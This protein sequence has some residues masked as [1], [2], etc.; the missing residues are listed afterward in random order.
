MNPI[1][2]FALVALPYKAEGA[3]VMNLHA[4]LDRMRFGEGIAPSE[5]DRQ[6][7][8]DTTAAAVKAF[9]QE[10]EI[11]AHAPGEIDPEAAVAMN[12]AALRREVFFVCVGAILQD[13]DEP[14]AD[15]ALELGDADNPGVCARVRSDAAG[16]YRAYFDP[17][18]YA[19]EGGDVRRRKDRPDLVLRA[20]APDGAERA[21]SE[22]APVAELETTIDLRLP[23]RAQPKP[24]ANE[25]FSV[26][27][28]VVDVD[29][30]PVSG[31][32]VRA[33]DR[34]VG[35]AR[36][37][38]G[39]REPPTVT[40]P[41]GAFAIAYGPSAFREG[42]GQGER[43]QR[44]DMLFTLAYEER[45]VE[46]FA[47][48]RLPVDGDPTIA[49]ALPAGV[50]E[51]TLG[52]VARPVERVRIVL[53]DVRAP[54]GPS[55]YER[56]AEA[57]APVTTR[58]T[59]ADFDEGAN[60]D[61]RFAARECGL[62]IEDVGDMAGAH[63]LARELNCAPEHAF[64][65]AR[66][67]GARDARAI[68][69]QA[70]AALAGALTRA[71][72][73]GLIPAPPEDGLD[74]AAAR[75]RDAAAR[76]AM[77]QP[78]AEGASFDASLREAIPDAQ[79]RAA[80]YARAAASGGL[81]DEAWASFAA[82]RPGVDVAR[83]R[84]AL[85]TAAL[86]G[87]TP[88]LA[89]RLRAA[90]PDAASLR[91]LALELGPDAIADAAAQA[92]PAPRDGEDAEAAA[93]RVASEI[94]GVLAATQTTAVVARDVAAVA[95][96]APGLVPQL[97]AD[98]LA[99]AVRATAFD[100]ARDRVS[101][102][103]AA[104]ADTLFAG[105]N[106]PAARAGATAGLHRVQRMFRVSPDPVTLKTALS[107]RAADGSSFRG[108][109]DIAR[110]SEDA[111]IAR[112]NATPEQA[113]GLRTLHRRAA[114]QAETVSTLLVGYHQEQNEA[115]LAL[116][117]V[118]QALGANAPDAAGDGP[119]AA[120]GPAAD[121]VASLRD[122]FGGA[123]TCDCEDC[124]SVMGPAAYLVDLFEFLDKRCADK[125]GVTLLDVLIGNPDKGVPGRR[126]DLARVKL[127]CENT[128]TTIPTID[129]INEILESL[130]AQGDPPSGLDSAG[131]PLESSFGVT[132]AE[133]SAAPENVQE[134]AYEA[135]AAAVF[136]LSL[137]FDRLVATARATMALANMERADLL[138]LFD[139]RLA[140]APGDA[141]GPAAARTA[142]QVERL[143]LFARDVEILTGM[144]IDGAPAAAPVETAAL[145]GLDGADWMTDLPK[146]RTALATLGVSFEQ[147]VALLRTR[148]VGGEVPDGDARDIRARV[149]LDVDELQI[150]RQPGYTGAP[151]AEIE[152]ALA[153][154]RI[155]R[156]DVLA[157]LDS[158]ARK[159]RLDRIW[160]LDPPIG[161]DLD[162][163]RLRTLDGGVLDGTDAARKP[164]NAADWRRL[165]GFVRLAKRMGVNFSDLDSAIEAVGPKA[166]EAFT[167]DHLRA[168]GAVAELRR[169]CDV[170]WPSA[171]ALV[172]GVGAHGDASLYAQL[173]LTSG[174]ARLHPAFRLDANGVP[175]SA[176]APLEDGV[177]GIA[178]ALRVS[179]TEIRELATTLNLATLS[180]DTVSALHRATAL[181]G[182]LGI[183]ARDVVALAGDLAGPSLG[184]PADAEALLAFVRRARLLLDGGLGATAAHAFVSDAPADWKPAAVT[185]AVAL[186]L[187]A[188][189]ED[190]S[191][192]QKD[193]AT[194]EAGAPDS[195]G[196]AADTLKARQEAR[197][198][199][200][201]FREE[202][203]LRR[204]RG[205]ALA[206]AAKAL[207]GSPVIVAKLLGA[208]DDPK[209]ALLR[210]G[211]RPALDVL[212]EGGDASAALL[213]AWR[214]IT[215]AGALG[216]DDAATARALGDAKLLTQARLT[217]APADRAE[218]LGEIA[219]AQ[220][221]NKD[222]NRPAAL[223]AAAALLIQAGGAVTGAV[224]AAVGRWLSTP[225]PAVA[226][227]AGSP[228][229]ALA[230][231]AAAI[232]PFA[233]LR[234]LKERVETLRKLGLTAAQAA[235]C[236]AEPLSAASLEALLRGV[237]SRFGASGWL[238]ASRRLFDPIREASRDALVPYLVR[239][240]GLSDADQL[241]GLYFI[242]VQTNSFVLTSR[243]RQAIF[244]VQIFVQRCLMGQEIKNGVDPGQVN[245]KEW[246]ITGRYPTWASLVQA[247]L[248]P[249]NLL[250]PGWRD[251]K[252]PAFVSFENA[253]RQS[254]ATPATAERAYS[255][256]L[257]SLCA[258]ASLEVCGTFMQTV[259][260]GDEAGVYTSVL[261]VV[262]RS[263]SGLPRKY[264]YRRLNRYD[265]H[266]EWTAWSPIGSEIQGIEKDRL[267]P[268]ASD[269]SNSALFDAGVHV[270]PM[271]HEGKLH[272]F[273][274]TLVRKVDQPE[275]PP[276][277]PQKKIN[278]SFS[279]P[280]W[281][282][283]LCWSKLEG[284]AWTPKQQSSALFESWWFDEP[285]KARGNS[286]GVTI[287]RPKPQFP[288]PADL[289]L[290][291]TG[292][293][294]D[295]AIV[296]G[297]RGTASGGSAPRAGAI[298]RFSLPVRSRE[299]VAS[300]LGGFVD[301]DH[302]GLSGS[303]KGSYMGFAASGAVKAT[304]PG[305]N[306]DGDRLFNA[307]AETRLVTL[308][309]GFGSPMQA[310]LFIG[311]LGRSYVATP[312]SGVTTIAVETP[313]GTKDH[314][315]WL[316][317]EA[318]TLDLTR[319]VTAPVAV[320][321]SHPWL[322]TATTEFRLSS[323]S[324][325]QSA[326]VPQEL[327]VAR[328]A[329]PVGQSF[330]ASRTAA[331][332]AAFLYGVGQVSRRNQD[333]EAVDLKVEPFWHAHAEDFAMTLRSGGL[334]ALLSP[335][336]QLQ[337]LG[338]A[339]S[340]MAVFGADP[341]R[342]TGPADEG[343]AFDASAPY[344][345]YNWEIF[346]HAPMLLT[347]RLWE[348]GRLDEALEWMH[349]VLNPL[350][351]GNDVAHAW[352][353][354]PLRQVDTTP[355]DQLLAALSRLDGDPQ[356]TAMLAQIEVLRLFPF[357][358]HRI[359]RLRPA[360]YRR[361]AAMQYILLRVAI[362]DRFFRQF[363]PED[364]NASIQHYVIA[365][366]CAGPR[367]E[368]T[369]SRTTLPAMS[370]AELRPRL[371]AFGNVAYEAETLLGPTAGATPAASTAAALGVV[372]RASIQYF[373]VPKNKKLLALWDLVED[374]LYK[375]RNG[376][377]I[378]GQQ[379]QLPLF[380]PPIDPALLAEAAA[381]G[382]DIADVA[383]ALSAPPPRRRFRAVHR[384]AA[385]LAEAVARLGAAL[386]ETRDRRDSEE[387]AY[388]RTENEK[389]L[390]DLILD[391]RREQAAEAA[392]AVES[393][394]AERQAPL[395]RW[396][397]YR[398]LLGANDLV[399]PT[400][401]PRPEDAGKDRYTMQR[402]LKLV[403]SSSVQVGTLSVL[404]LAP[405]LLGAAFGG[406]GGA[407][408]MGLTGAGGSSTV[409]GPGFIAGGTIL[410]EEAGE[411][412]ESFIAADMAAE[413][414]N[415]EIL[416]SVLQ[417]I[418]S[419]EA[420]VKPLGGG[421]AVHFGG[422][423]LA[424]VQAAFSRQKQALGAAHSFFAGLLSKQAGFVLREHEWATQL[425]QAAADIKRAEKAAAVARLRKSAADKEVL[426]Q[427]AAARHAEQV[428][429][430]LEQKFTRMELYDYRI[431]RQMELFRR[432]FDVA[433]E[434]ALM[435]Q[436]SYGYEREPRTFMRVSKPA[437]ARGELMAGHELL[438]CLADM[439]RAY[440]DTPDL[441]EI[442]RQVSLRHIAPLALWDL[443][444][445]GEAR[446]TIPE[447][448]LDIDHPGHYDRRLRSVQVTIPYLQ[449]P[450]A[451]LTGELVL[452]S[453]KLRKTA[454]T[455]GM[456]EIQSDGITQAQWIALSTVREDG[457][458]FELSSQGDDYMPFE[459]RGAVSTWTLRLPWTYRRL[460]YRAISDVV[461]TLRYVAKPGG[462]PARLAAEDRIGKIYKMVESLAKAPPGG[463]TVLLSLAHDFPDAW[464]AFQQRP[465]QPIRLDKPEQTLP[466]LFRQR[467]K[468]EVAAAEF[469]LMPK[470]APAG[471]WTAIAK[472]QQEL[473]FPPGATPDQLDDIAVRVAFS[474]RPRD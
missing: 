251:D 313:K 159:D 375:V 65:L 360:A 447:E 414:S 84:F 143:G 192:E 184:A 86:A 194:A 319:G 197:D 424:G 224:A 191:A 347:K 189:A 153:L 253:L 413:A 420:A 363:T 246:R 432:C 287:L 305:Q 15:V 263:R 221:C 38:L 219:A 385:A 202:R 417:I 370:Y 139:P 138:A 472:D 214:F 3:E 26:S 34:D 255:D 365:R 425:H 352:R 321:P 419:I 456:A 115:G 410:A 170:S 297:L 10:F 180:L 67:L 433:L 204:R 51:L 19:R 397:H 41:E 286:I 343:V 256:Y 231:D 131:K 108:A 359:A 211:A 252:T 435:A 400:A 431:E 7:Y 12:E 141:G 8:G 452:E 270:L 54:R 43:A 33:W 59:L 396:T 306:R 471:G 73:D 290:K 312:S 206:A 267:S 82:E 429:T 114:G 155:T 185:A 451:P 418:P 174:V 407:A 18:F 390:A 353:F 169:L 96:Q 408:A 24:P 150:L 415:I 66:V 405:L 356:K 374:R 157:L 74:D 411:I 244:A 422:Q 247:L 154:G 62:A 326:F 362:G 377:N 332:G 13:D 190:D 336:T 83:A 230:P 426:S 234:M 167:L 27:G 358:A 465:D 275:P 178:A 120:D 250:E 395:E 259:F 124:R 205:V 129:L 344:G 21:R 187:A 37:P 423:Q 402:Q 17:L 175:L 346:F 48:I 217:G 210:V 71:G 314:L 116:A 135:V 389:E 137:P 100:L 235:A 58:V 439:D 282:V 354:T 351:Y 277:D 160:V 80:L 208:A 61:V 76:R 36:E 106:D 130:V 280:Y 327:A 384:E 364:V 401:T 300:A 72:A 146:V 381:A 168:L 272:L 268:R 337:S 376:M 436:A 28:V 299:M 260:E 133:L 285:I 198:E 215:L 223:A 441:A 92:R 166:D 442:T 238:E 330:G 240:K 45:A 176:G 440:I 171:A 349:R 292:I 97:T 243:I 283:K 348:N 291:A 216:W 309:Q 278:P 334:D 388:K 445:T 118:G 342:V 474:A 165:N 444:E 119:P 144:R 459:G 89:E 226:D 125:N 368:T 322:A 55:L 357:R 233:A 404:N 311:A 308:N 430:Y 339:R 79:A 455:M 438:A 158:P 122:F 406:A 52:L 262:G 183:P 457:G 179:P 323:A 213:A 382:L 172:G 161:C 4:F 232:R 288:K 372:R 123:E 128:N 412:N 181:A 20:L 107:V 46:R 338:A 236:V 104:H 222:T 279:S 294:N 91:V 237:Q 345:G 132:G 11:R 105:E 112:A 199:Q 2:L 329:A 101:D 258:V 367:P 335:E 449:T 393:A 257:D 40:D 324:L 81:D 399:E 464:S 182:V 463:P 193:N 276:I 428:K 386:S 355:I 145:F 5:R 460:N 93:R 42:E 273:W 147:L 325:V 461:L 32:T 78:L 35:P 289:I 88:G 148:F 200:T 136:P 448:M 350:D 99:R 16:L 391:T 340:F 380:S 70:P 109:L 409:S 304:P 242:D 49:D 111:F 469:A 265:H 87:G 254:D 241:F 462:A 228:F 468:A 266:Q 68:A 69:A 284:E 467:M 416:G 164:R 25:P 134:K 301:G 318:K 434:R 394:E 310:P 1:L 371:N 60:A 295:A 271:V 23:A 95:R 75:L 379:I 383:A 274:P 53:D 264:F 140:E 245:T 269:G 229:G 152:E 31:V 64:A 328:I 14:A 427:E 127:S 341:A 117:G 450:G 369:V 421:V 196:V 307:P 392:K 186:A 63:R 316:V 203:R 90:A 173:F 44:A 366:A 9:Q 201:L 156:A 454:P 126:P 320:A 56:L 443:R 293:G 162:G 225:D 30:Q 47:I 102:L 57:L 94:A 113:M 373:G 470:G 378:D 466:W 453:A 121:M 398:H 298:A 103:V 303:L 218:A 29:G 163:M 110:L 361:W 317:E 195:T 220:L 331:M 177:P 446:F 248:Y 22:P 296:L 212:T 261:H 227:A 207:G 77:A 387:L 281:E 39:P 239:K 302:V 403:D 315:P 142:A 209:A 50:D 458:R 85:Q 437:D 151:I 98:A 149:Y 473:A 188:P 6:A 333:V 249:E